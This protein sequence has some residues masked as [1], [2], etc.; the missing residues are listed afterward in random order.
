MR[1]LKSFLIS[2]SLLFSFS[3]YAQNDTLGSDY[4]S[5]ELKTKPEIKSLMGPTTSVGR[6]ASLDIGVASFEG[7]RFLQLGVTGAVITN[8]QFSLGLTVSSFVYPF[9]KDSVDFTNSSDEGRSSERYGVFGGVHIGYTIFPKEPVH[10]TFPLALGAGVYGVK[11]YYD[12][13]VFIDID[14]DRW[15][16]DYEGEA[17]FFIRPGVKVEMNISSFCMFA[18]GLEYL[19]TDMNIKGYEPSGMDNMSISTSIKLGSF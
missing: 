17:L 10:I 7:H 15:D 19:Y 11:T 3:V 16:R 4:E 1:I 12:E 8:H 9:D 5:V 18:I 14:R 13:N 6:Y 2:F